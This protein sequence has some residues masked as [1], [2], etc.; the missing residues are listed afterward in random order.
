[1]ANIISVDYYWIASYV[2]ASVIIFAGF[3]YASIKSGEILRK[4]L[5][6]LLVATTLINGGII[7]HALPVVQLGFDNVQVTEILLSHILLFFGFV[8]LLI[9][10]KDI[11]DISEKI[12]F[13]E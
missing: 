10:G 6:S 11:K 13:K 8:S 9:P 2:I 4:A 3:L 7:L 5:V 1:M 12:G